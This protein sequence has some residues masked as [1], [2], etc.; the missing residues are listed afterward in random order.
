MKIF[1]FYFIVNKCTENFFLTTTTKDT[2]TT[3]TGTTGE[4][5]IDAT[6]NIIAATEEGKKYNL[7]T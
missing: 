5:Q 4:E 3:P 1:N 7:I 2:T 6:G